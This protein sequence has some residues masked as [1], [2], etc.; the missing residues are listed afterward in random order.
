MQSEMRKTMR[1]KD[2]N[3]RKRVNVPPPAGVSDGLKLLREK[4]YLASLAE[5]LD[6]TPGAVRKWVEVPA[7]RVVAVAGLS[8][9]LPHDLR[10][11]LYA[12]YRYIGDKKK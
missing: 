6:L 4:V 2:P 10:P 7:E 9:L 12:G 1:L 11:D 5:S 3:R 8:G